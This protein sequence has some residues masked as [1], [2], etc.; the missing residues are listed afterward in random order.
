MQLLLNNG[1]DVNTKE[2]DYTILHEVAR[3]PHVEAARF[4]LSMG[5]RLTL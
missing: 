4:Y 3:S 1:A 2:C 5:Q